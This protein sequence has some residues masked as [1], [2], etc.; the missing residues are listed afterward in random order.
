MDDEEAEEEGGSE[1]HREG[2]P[3][4][5]RRSPP[6]RGR[7]RED[8]GPRRPRRSA[9]E[10][11]REEGPG[12]EAGRPRKAAPARKARRA[13]PAKPRRPARPAVEGLDPDGYFV[14]RVRG[15]EAARRAPH[16]MTEGEEREDP[17]ALRALADVPV[18]RRRRGARR[19]ALELRR[20]RLRGPAARS[21]H[22]VLLLG[23]LRGDPQ[24]R[25]SSGWT[26]R[27]PSSGSSRSARTGELG[28]RARRRVR[29]R[30]ARLLRPRPRAR[31]AP[32]AA[33]SWPSRPTA[34]SGCVGE[35]SNEVALPSS[36]PSPVVDD[37]F[38]TIP[39]ELPLDGWLRDVRPRRPFPRG[40]PR[41]AGAPL[42]GGEALGAGLG[43]AH[44]AGRPLL[45][46]QGLGRRQA[47]RREGGRLDGPRRP[48][49][50]L[51]P[52][53]RAPAVRA[54]PGAR[55]VP[56]GGLALRG[57]HRDLP[58]AAAD[59]RPAH[60]RG[61]PVP[62]LDDHVA[63]AR[64][65][66]A[67]RPAHGALREAARAALR[68]DRQGGPAHPPRPHLPRAGPVLPARVPRAARPLRGP[69]R[70]RPGG[71]L[72]PAGGGRAARAHHLRRHPRLPAA[73]AGVPRGG[74]RADRGRRRQ[75]PA[76]LRPEPGRHLAA[77][78]RLL[79]G[80]RRDARRAGHPLLL[81]RH[82]RH[83]R[84]HARARATG[85]TRRSSPR[86]GRPP[87][88]RDPES[89]QQV[90]SAEHGYPGDPEYREFY[91][92]IGWDLD[93]EYIKPYIQPDGNR[94]NVGIKYFRITGKGGHKEPYDP[95]RARERAAAHAGNFMFNRERQIEHLA[96][97]HGRHAAHRGLA[98]RRRALRPLVVR[99]AAV[100]RLPDPQ[101]GLRPEGLPAGHAR[102]TTCAR[103]RSSSWPRRRS[104]P[105]APAATPGSG[106][107]APTT[108]STATCT[109]RPSG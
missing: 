85:S 44:R 14:A 90:W 78:V 23:P 109:R 61:D 25:P 52:P 41:H 33:R 55:R 20:R 5:A 2:P 93:C 89:S 64:G 101:G 106:S 15:E 95:R 65:H 47:R 8:G 69:L 72:P 30:V 59:L 18:P 62:D 50:P 26:A 4:R 6:R 104:A 45:P 81:H 34:G 21:A 54:P 24:A 75:P 42:Q 19:P 79:P 84:R 22:A 51:A 40:D 3:R 32:T 58:A 46:D 82:P 1:A 76:P 11:V 43:R 105:G 7:A 83:R 80:R 13:A 102:A 67:R 99:G 98:L 10:G 86:A 56:R 48:G 27:A 60:R 49:L 73:D 63:A 28:A 9:R 12:R 68:A 97:Q 91:R 107:T 31:A 38:A 57:H 96:G 100:H 94:K 17:M 103:T 35:P 66:A 29:A 16:P 77:R 71:R 39:W 37:R 74:P 70:P 87:S 108:G 36:G 53:P 88:R 92:D